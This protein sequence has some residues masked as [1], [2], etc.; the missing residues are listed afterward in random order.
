[1]F[2]KQLCNCISSLVGWHIWIGAD[3]GEEVCAYA[4]D[5]F[6]DRDDE[7][8]E[9]VEEDQAQEA[10]SVAGQEPGWGCQ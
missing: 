1:M 7:E 9:D 6:K 3:K 5:G 8:C 4:Y 10:G 2:L